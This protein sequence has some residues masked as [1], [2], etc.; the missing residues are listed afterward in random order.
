MDSDLLKL[1]LISDPVPVP[2]KNFCIEELG[3]SSLS[4]R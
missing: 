1:V 2:V 3:G 4:R